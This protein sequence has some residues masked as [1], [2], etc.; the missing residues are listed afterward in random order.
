MWTVVPSATVKRGGLRR[1][2]RPGDRG[3][4]A[5]AVASV[6][7]GPSPEPREE[8]PQNAHQQP[9]SDRC[10]AASAVDAAPRRR[11]GFQFGRPPPHGR[12]WEQV[13]RGAG[14]ACGLPGGDGRIEQCHTPLHG[15]FCRFGG[16]GPR[17][18]HTVSRE[19]NGKL[20]CG[21][22]PI[23]GAARGRHVGAQQKKPL[24]GLEG[25]WRRQADVPKCHRHT[26]AWVH[27]Y[28]K[29]FPSSLNHLY[30]LLPDTAVTGPRL[31]LQLPERRAIPK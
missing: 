1:L 31:Q 27:A 29:V 26:A 24:A 19:G 23:R 9:S 21:R 14:T 3:Q 4:T 5:Q 20:A 15:R 13:G 10:R 8:P 30:F 7:L 11:G 18:G 17:P 22:V 16:S 25:D 2:V 12:S 28:D 6:P